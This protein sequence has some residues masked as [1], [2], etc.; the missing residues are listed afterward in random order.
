MSTTAHRNFGRLAQA[1]AVA[2]VLTTATPAQAVTP[3]QVTTSAQATAATRSH[4]ARIMVAD[5]T[6]QTFRIPY[7]ASIAEGTITFYN[8]SL[9]ITGYVKAVSASRTV[10]FI[11]YNGNLSCY[12]DETRTASAGTTRTYGFDETCDVAGG[13]YAVDVYFPV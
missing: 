7:G 10:E 6:T 1:L 8:R 3:T 13:F 12:F 4:V 9:N 11:G 5:S 2:A